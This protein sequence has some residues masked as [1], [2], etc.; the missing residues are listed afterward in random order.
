MGVQ[1]RIWDR[2]R[3]VRA[4][5]PTPDMTAERMAKTSDDVVGTRAYIL[6]GESSRRETES[7]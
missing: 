3:M 1:W 5:V 2:E 7:R 6:V 4:H